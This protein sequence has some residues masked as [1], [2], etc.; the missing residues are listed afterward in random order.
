MPLLLP[1]D[2]IVTVYFS[3][4]PLFPGTNELDQVSKIHN[5]LGTPDSTLLH[6]FKQYVLYLQNVHRN[7]VFPY[8]TKHNLCVD[9]K[10]NIIQPCSFECLAGPGQCVLTS[11][12]RRALASPGYYLTVLPQ[13]CH[14]FIKCL[15]MT[16]MNESLQKQ[17]CN[18]HTS[19]TSGRTFVFPIF[20]IDS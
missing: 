13:L 7:N 10:R 19:E 6:K 9:K 11:P 15:L 17:H 12:L 20:C 2:N 4:N 1:T 16:L 14:C 5:V 18:T 3:L 8:K